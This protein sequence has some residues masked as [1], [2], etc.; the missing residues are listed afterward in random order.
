MSFANPR[1]VR[2]HFNRAANS[3]DSAAVLQRELTQRLLENFDY[4]KV[5]P[6][7]VLDAGCGTGAALS[8]LRE[9]FPTTH[10][11]ALDLAENMVRKAAPAPS[12][13][14]KYLRKTFVNGIAADF[15][16]LPIKSASVDVIVSNFALHWSPDLAATMKELARVL[17][18]GG[19]LLFTVPGPDTLK[20][21]RRATHA[22]HT[23]PDMHDVGD[24]M[25]AEG[26]ADP[27]MARDDL[28]LTYDTPDALLADMKSLGVTFAGG[29]KKGLMGKAAFA[30][31]KAKLERERVTHAKPGVPTAHIGK[32]PAT[33]EV[34]TGHAW[35]VAATKTED[36][37]AIVQFD[38]KQR[39]RR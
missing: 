17:K 31:L 8:G 22:V 34:V 37:R 27:V 28:V 20:E 32:I 1:A 33:Y 6:S 12:L 24:M 14:A 36:G 19:L 9:R 26:L 23:F 38:P 39:G 25:V 5:A 30:A 10:I 29:E 21:L 4:M 18:V 7:L 2:K 3:Y 15:S 35:K 13:F 11:L 16:F